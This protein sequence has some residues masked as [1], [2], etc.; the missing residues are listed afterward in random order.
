MDTCH[1]PLLQAEGVIREFEWYRC[2]RCGRT[3]D[4]KLS[5][6]DLTVTVSRGHPQKKEPQ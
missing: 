2:M 4:V 1:H 3:F 6:K 5:P